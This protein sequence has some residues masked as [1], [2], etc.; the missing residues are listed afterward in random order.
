MENNRYSLPPAGQMAPT[1][2]RLRAFY[3]M[4]PDA[5]LVQ[6]EFGF[7]VLDRWIREGFL[8]PREEV[9]DYD[10][11]LRE[12]FGYDA[13]AV[14]SLGGLGWCEAGFFPAFEETV[15]EDRG[16]YEL[17][18]D[19]A[20]R[21]VL[22]F[23]GRRDGFMPEY[24]DHPVK[25]WKTWEEDVKWRL[26][27]HAPGRLEQTQWQVSYALEHAPLGFVTVQQLVGGY[28]YLRSLM[29]P[30]QLLYLFYD[31]PA[32]IHDC[33]KTWFELADFVIAH[34]QKSVPLD[35]IFIG[36]DICY[37]HGSLI[38]PDM[39]REF[40]FPYYQ[41]LLQNARR[42]NLDPDR[43]LHF[44]VD[45]D[46]YCGGVL[47]LYREIGCDFM[48]PF[49][50]AAGC[51]V[52]RFGREYPRLRISGGIDKRVLAQG[53]DAIDRHLDAILPV[54]RRRGGYLPT[55]DHGVPEEVPFENYLHFRRRM[56]EY[57]R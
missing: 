42:R 6:R 57:A 25:D 44:Q 39:I 38:S 11:Y 5:P 10:A 55:C 45:T 2:R 31:A 21:S 26:D 40:L 52:V 24:V 56:L 41:Q 20:G 7:Y 3:E 1:A 37:N 14:C 23:K 48:S 28:M 27:P 46:G 19:F 34:H 35:E 8:K 47:P 15:L 49:E 30:E 29:G 22:Y 18:R 17:V 16:E 4:T 54:M 12:L 32:L 13:P 43:P 36:E 33:M 50:V 53:C 9:A 51:D